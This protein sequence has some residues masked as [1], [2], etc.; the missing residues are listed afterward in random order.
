MRGRATDGVRAFRRMSGA[1]LH[2]ALLAPIASRILW[3]M[4]L[5]GRVTWPCCGFP[6]LHAFHWPDGLV[7]LAAKRE[8]ACGAGSRAPVRALPEGGRVRWS[9]WRERIRLAR[10]PSRAPPARHQRWAPDELLVTPEGWQEIKAVFQAA[11]ERPP[12]ERAAFLDQ[13]SGRAP[14]PRA[15]PPRNSHRRPAAAP[16]HPLGTRFG[17]GRYR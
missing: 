1:V 12:G 5:D 3:I 8:R 4:T 16:P 14:G 7:A 15:L 17:R 11:L 13:A 2:G 9:A 10:E 6:T